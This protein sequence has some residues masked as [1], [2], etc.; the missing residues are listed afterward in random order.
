MA[1]VC[2]KRAAVEEPKDELDD[3]IAEE[4]AALARVQQQRR[5]AKRTAAAAAALG[6]EK[7]QSRR[8]ADASERPQG[9]ASGAGGTGGTGKKLRGKLWDKRHDMKVIAKPAPKKP[10]KA[11]AVDLF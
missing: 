6:S 10:G 4:V 8:P 11:K 2:L 9:G 1:S 7:Q 3:G 5:E